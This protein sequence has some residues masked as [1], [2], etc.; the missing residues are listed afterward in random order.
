[1]GSLDGVAPFFVEYQGVTS[2]H[3]DKGGNFYEN[4]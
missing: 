3:L 2:R 4:G 1:M